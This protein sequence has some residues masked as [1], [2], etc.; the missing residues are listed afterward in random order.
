MRQRVNDSRDE[1]ASCESK[2]AKRKKFER[3]GRLLTYQLTIKLVFFF[4]R[5]FIFVSPHSR[6][7]VYRCCSLVFFVSVLLQLRSVLKTGKQATL[8]A[9]TFPPS[10]SVLIRHVRRMSKLAENFVRVLLNIYKWTHENFVFRAHWLSSL[11]NFPFAGIFPS[12]SLCRK[13]FFSPRRKSLYALFLP[14]F[15]LNV[16]RTL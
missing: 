15:P 9:S 1:E 8:C 11:R 13:T 6:S 5:K 7:L 10:I 16:Q 12:L 2:Q 3:L 4:T 14:F